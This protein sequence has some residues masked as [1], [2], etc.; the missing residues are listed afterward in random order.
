MACKPQP[1]QVSVL[2]AGVFADKV[3]HRMVQVTNDATFYTL[4]RLTKQFFS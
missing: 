4:L 3:D 2:Q 1:A